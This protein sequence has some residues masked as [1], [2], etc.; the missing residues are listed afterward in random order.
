M[1]EDLWARV[2][3]CYDLQ[4]EENRWERE[5]RQDPP[6]VGRTIGR[7]AKPKPGYPS[8]LFNAFLT[9]PLHYFI[10]LIFIFGIVPR[11]DAAKVLRRGYYIETYHGGSDGS[12]RHGSDSRNRWPCDG[13]G[14]QG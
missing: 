11:Q 7:P 4:I 10:Y 2:Q 14:S 9:D 12:R 1:G 8:I 13:T 3:A 5:A 6:A